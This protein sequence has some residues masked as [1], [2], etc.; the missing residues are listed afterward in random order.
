MRKSLTNSK[1]QLKECLYL[2]TLRLLS[3]AMEI[4]QHNSEEDVETVLPLQGKAM[5]ALF[6]ALP[7]PETLVTGRSPDLC[8]VDGYSL[9]IK[10]LWR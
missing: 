6:G 4:N 7:P 5:S 3:I 10:S 9:L 8:D 2:E 1:E